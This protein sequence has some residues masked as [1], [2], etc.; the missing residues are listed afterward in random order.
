M[1]VGMNV[2]I[3]PFAIMVNKENEKAIENLISSRASRTCSFL[4]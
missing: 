3:G 1:M 4:K 2:E